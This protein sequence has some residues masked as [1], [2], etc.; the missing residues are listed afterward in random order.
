VLWT[1]AVLAQAHPQAQAPDPNKVAEGRQVFKDSKCSKCHGIEGRG[2]HDQ[3]VLRGVGEKLSA[4]EIRQWITHPAEMTAK[5]PKKP[6]EPMKKVD[7]TEAQVD[8]LVAYL[9]SLKK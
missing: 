6:K 8:A 1:G 5:L 3:R 9:Q 4:A 2:E 7:L